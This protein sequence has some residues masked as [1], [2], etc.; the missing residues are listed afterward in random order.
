MFFLC[1]A[2]H[3]PFYFFL[4]IFRVGSVSLTL[5]VLGLYAI[6]LYLTL[7]LFL[8]LLGSCLAVKR[9]NRKFENLWEYW[10]TERIVLAIP[11]QSTITTGRKME[12]K[13]MDIQL[14]F[15]SVRS[16]YQLETVFQVFWY[17]VNMC[18]VFSIALI[19]GLK[20]DTAYTFFE[21]EDINIIEQEEFFSA[22]IWTIFVSGW[23]SIVLFFIQIRKEVN[24]TMFDTGISKTI[25]QVVYSF[26]LS[27]FF[28]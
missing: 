7:F 15:P 26:L 18:I 21:M 13:F 10:Q 17:V 14:N 1:S 25:T 6:P 8:F 24:L 16:K 23:I 5:A 9:Y 3:L 19:V 28:K 4:T 22:V 2:K 20:Y 12:E 27:L 11:F